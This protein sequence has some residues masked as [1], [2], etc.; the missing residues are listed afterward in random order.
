MQTVLRA[1]DRATGKTVEIPTESYI[2]QTQKLEAMFKAG[3]TQYSHVGIYFLEP[4]Q[5][6]PLKESTAEVAAVPPPPAPETPKR[7][8]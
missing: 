1:T 8:K 4:K 3:S 6:V 5:V 2:E 7:R